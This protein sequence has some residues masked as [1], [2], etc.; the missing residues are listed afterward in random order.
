M[1]TPHESAEHQSIREE[2]CNTQLLGSEGACR[3]YISVLTGID[4]FAL[5]SNEFI[6][7]VREFIMNETAGAAGYF[8]FDGY[9]V[10]FMMPFFKSQYTKRFSIAGIDSSKS[11]RAVE[12][13]L[14]NPFWTDEQIASAVSTTLKQLQRFSGYTVLRTPHFIKSTI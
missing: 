7:N 5:W 1:A 11:D 9:T 4:H 6:D 2:M 3:Y 13:L 12:L 14:R 8:Q 10:G